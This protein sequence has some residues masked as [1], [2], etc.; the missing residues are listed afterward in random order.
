MTKKKYIKK[1]NVHMEML[2]E[3]VIALRKDIDEK[4]AIIRTLQRRWRKRDR[5]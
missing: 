3:E 1:M 5:G 4:E 2:E